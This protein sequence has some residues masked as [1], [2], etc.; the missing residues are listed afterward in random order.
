[1][2]WMGL[3]LLGACGFHSHDVGGDAQGTSDALST[4]DSP[5]AGSPDAPPDAANC[6]G[7]GL[8]TVCLA[9]TPGG[10]YDV[11]VATTTAVATDSA[12]TQL[13]SQSAG[14]RMCVVAGVDVHI[15]GTLDAT[16]T[17]PL[18]VLA[19]NTLEISGTIDASS[20]R[21]VQGANVTGEH[22]GAGEA[23]VSLCGLPTV[24]GDDASGGA[25]GGAGGSFGGAGG[26]GAA[27]R[28]GAGGAAGVAALAM[29]PTMVRGGC[30]GTAGGNYA[31]SLGGKAGHGGGAVY[32]IAGAQITIS[33]TVQAA[34]EGGDAGNIGGGGGG[35]GAGGL[36]GLDAPTVSVTGTVYAN[37]GGGGEG[38]GMNGG[39]AMG[40][41]STSATIAAAGGSY[42]TN[43]GD[44]GAG[45]VSTTLGGGPG[46]TNNN[47]GGAGGGGAGVIK[48][49]PAQTLG[50]TVSPPAT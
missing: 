9:A 47:G 14:P 26:G 28:N 35:G 24:G 17:L 39:G 7:G 32:L 27:G 36:I 3:V 16:G 40:A 18:V 37:G 31:S 11:P 50:G 30:A 5:H 44:G 12:C 4:I 8:A 34:G 42:N 25:G 49:H 10:N 29:T 1:M 20:Y 19:T 45:S 41:S 15:D 2:R 21:I 23:S 13:V 22:I 43:G 46:Q 48:V 38:G 33:G 6:Y